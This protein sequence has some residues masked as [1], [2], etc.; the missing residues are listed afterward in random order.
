VNASLAIED[1]ADLG[2]DPDEFLG[3]P[4]CETCGETIEL[5]RGI[6]QHTATRN[7]FCDDAR[8]WSD[9]TAWPAADNAE[10]P[11]PGCTFEYAIQ[12]ADD[13]TYHTGFDDRRGEF[14]PTWTNF[15]EAK[16]EFYRVR[17]CGLVPHDEHLRSAQLVRR[18]V[19]AWTP[20]THMGY[21]VYQPE[22]GAL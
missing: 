1:G 3:L 19:P 12:F 7:L 14:V 20:V 4:T 2:S 18:E 10:K 8:S 5:Q 21:P 11:S 13:G 6:W 16:D 9:K 15:A 22:A 17:G